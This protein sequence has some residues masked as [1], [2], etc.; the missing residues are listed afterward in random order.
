MFTFIVQTIS[1]K[2]LVNRL[3]EPVRFRLL[4]EI[5]LLCFFTLSRPLS[6][7]GAAGSKAHGLGT[8]PRT[9]EMKSGAMSEMELSGSMSKGIG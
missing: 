8:T 3:G 1:Y 9:C 6:I 5:L 7:R 4:E 2:C